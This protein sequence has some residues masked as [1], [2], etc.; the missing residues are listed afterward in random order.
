MA[1]EAGKVIEWF[2]EALVAAQIADFPVG[3]ALFFFVV[4]DFDAAFGRVGV[5][6]HLAHPALA[7][8][9]ILVQGYQCAIHKL[10]HLWL[11]LYRMAAA[12]LFVLHVI[13][14]F[15][16]SLFGEEFFVGA[17]LDDPTVLDDEYPR[18]IFNG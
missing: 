5:L 6:I 16:L 13:K 15:I 2:A 1:M 9:K 4:D 7:D 12:G 18:G 10:S 3:G 14:V 11:W 17:L 8:K